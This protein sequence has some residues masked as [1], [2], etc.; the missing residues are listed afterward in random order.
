MGNHSCVLTYGLTAPMQCA[1]L[2]METGI[3]PGGKKGGE[4]K[5]EVG[6]GGG[7]GGGE[8]FSSFSIL[9]GEGE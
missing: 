2:K 1:G 8:V 9:G 5:G 3:P 4:S 7:G 6:G